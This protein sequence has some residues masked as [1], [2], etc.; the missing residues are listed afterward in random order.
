MVWTDSKSA[1]SFAGTRGLA[2]AKLFY[3]FRGGEKIEC[4]LEPDKQL[5]VRI[6]TFS[7]KSAPICVSHTDL[8]ALSQTNAMGASTV[9]RTNPFAISTNTAFCWSGDSGR[10]VR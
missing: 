5:F 1:I 8:P 6:G 9:F 10:F 3:I 2:T 7:V 4:A